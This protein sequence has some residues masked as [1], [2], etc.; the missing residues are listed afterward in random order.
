MGLFRLCNRSWWLVET[1]PWYANRLKTISRITVQ[2]AQHGP[3][4]A[5]C[6]KDIGSA[7][8]IGS[9]ECL[10]ALQKMVGDVSRTKAGFAIGV[11]ERRCPGA[12]GS[13]GRFREEKCRRTASAGQT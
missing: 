7:S 11:H 4:L 13:H 5:S 1:S 10:P 3:I 6:L 12:A 8:V 2:I 9:A